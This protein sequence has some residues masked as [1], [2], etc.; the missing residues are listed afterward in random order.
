M[1]KTQILDQLQRS[2]LDS[3]LLMELE[4]FLADFPDEMSDSDMDQL[5]MKLAKLQDEEKQM[6]DEMSEASNEIEKIQDDM[7]DSMNAAVV[8]VVTAMRDAVKDVDQAQ[9]IES[10]Y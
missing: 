4:V 5:D 10:F 6:M 8:G 2:E 7:E 9:K 3:N 1:N